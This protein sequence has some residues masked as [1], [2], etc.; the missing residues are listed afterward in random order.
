MVRYLS[1][2]LHDTLVFSTDL[3]INHLEVNLVLLRGEVVHNGIVCC[4][5]ILVLLGIEGGEND[6]VGFKM[7]GGQDVLITEASSDGE[8]TFVVCVELGY[9]FGTMCISFDQ[10]GG[11]GPISGLMFAVVLVEDL[12]LGLVDWTTCQVWLR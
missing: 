10:M 6:C 2:Y 4:N 1:V 7:V 11:K 3:V 8:D 9:Q 5:A 12:V